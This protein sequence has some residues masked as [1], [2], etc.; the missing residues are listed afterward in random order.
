MD[1]VEADPNTYAY[2]SRI[3][4]TNQVP[5]NGMRRDLIRKSAQI[6]YSLYSEHQ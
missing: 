4:E 3:L 2:I 5:S 6:E 1:T